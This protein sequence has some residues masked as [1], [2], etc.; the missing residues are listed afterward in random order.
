VF[1]LGKDLFLLEGLT[2]T[3]T[4][5]IVISILATDG[6]W[7]VLD[8]S[9]EA[10]ASVFWFTSARSDSTSRLTPLIYR[11]RLT[12]GADRGLKVLCSY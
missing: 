1:A 6:L 12:R 5:C 10:C 3:I 9:P 7:G 4:I 11:L 8:V 2:I